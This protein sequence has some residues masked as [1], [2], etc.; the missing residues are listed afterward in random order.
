MARE[1]L[2]APAGRSTCWCKASKGG[3]RSIMSLLPA[4]SAVRSCALPMETTYKAADST[5]VLFHVML[6]YVLQPHMMHLTQFVFVRTLV[7]SFASHH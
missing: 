7:E 4:A 5:P 2:L 6:Q 1:T 3:S